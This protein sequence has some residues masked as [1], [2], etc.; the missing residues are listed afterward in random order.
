MT[1]HAVENTGSSATKQTRSNRLLLDQQQHKIMRNPGFRR[2]PQPPVSPPQAI[3]RHQQG[4][5]LIRAAISRFGIVTQII[6]YRSSGFESLD[7]AAM[8]SVLEWKFELARKSG[9]TVA[10]WVQV[11]VNF[12]L[13]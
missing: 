11:P 12:V 9:V 1:A 10:S 2:K 5:T 4:T 13:K 3:R 7:R 8:A 6:I